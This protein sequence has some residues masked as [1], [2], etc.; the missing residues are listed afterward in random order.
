MW[1][2]EALLGFAVLMGLKILELVAKWLMFEYYHQDV[3]AN[4][5]KE[6]WGLSP[7]TIQE[8]LNESEVIL[9]EYAYE[10]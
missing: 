8:Y 7:L 9:L 2:G 3:D 5:L 6:N 10:R 1:L 4:Q